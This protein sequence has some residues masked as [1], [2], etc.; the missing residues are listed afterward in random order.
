MLE[1]IIFDILNKLE[2]NEY[3]AYIVGGYVR[4]YLKNIKSKDIDICTSAKPKEVMK[5][6]K[7]YSPVSLD[8]G[9]VIMEIDD[10]N[11]EIT[12][13][14]KEYNYKNNRYPDK[15]EYVSSLKE[16]LDR[17]DFTINSICMDKNCNII[18]LLNGKKDFSRRII[19]S[20][21]DPNIKLKEDALRIMR[22][23][24]F[25]TVLNFKIEDS[26]KK[27]IIDNKKLLKNLSYERK[28]EELTKIFA[29]ENK[30]YGIKILQDLKLLEELELQNINNVLLTKDIIGMWSTITKND[31]YPFTR[32][33]KELIKDIKLLLT[34][35]LNDNFVLY[36]YGI[37]SISVVCDLKR[38]NKRKII[39]R[40]NKLPIKDK[41]EIKI[42]SE[43]ICEILNKDPGP[44]LKEIYNNIEVLIIRKELVNTKEAI[45]KYILNI[46][47][48]I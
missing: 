47:D 22:A 13:F 45:E 24:R 23:I 25:A 48:V 1:K 4:D 28:K 44:F 17:R 39:D 15:I 30:K 36:K 38:L 27:A 19:K 7:D 2:E 18:D 12:T 41:K 33:E 32:N 40:Y 37:Y 31:N 43:E 46:N 8:Y 14:R 42:T 34:E 6:F 26:L 9:N 10:Y 35:N 11:F 21:K 16:D 5:I 3:E 20:I 29:S